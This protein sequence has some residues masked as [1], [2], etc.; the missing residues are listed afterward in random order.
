MYMAKP[1]MQKLARF[2]RMSEESRGVRESHE[3]WEIL[4]FRTVI[5]K[6][7]SNEYTIHNIRYFN[8]IGREKNL[9]MRPS[10]GYLVD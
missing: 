9:L 6:T 5:H 2:I 1:L 3:V 4:H 7:F 8:I 10:V